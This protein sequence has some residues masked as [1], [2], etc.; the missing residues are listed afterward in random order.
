M[1]DGEVAGMVQA[2]EKGPRDRGVLIL[3]DSK[4]C[5]VGGEDGQARTGELARGSMEA[6]SLVGTTPS[7]ACSS[8][9]VLGEGTCRHHRQ[10]AGR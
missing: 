5:A 3:A 1:W 7:K 2:L 10:R 8:E 9:V 6:C 4:A